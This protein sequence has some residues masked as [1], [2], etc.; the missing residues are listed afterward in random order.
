[1]EYKGGGE[2]DSKV[3]LMLPYLLRRKTHKHIEGE[4][5]D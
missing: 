2:V 3:T 5:K 1:M 4:R